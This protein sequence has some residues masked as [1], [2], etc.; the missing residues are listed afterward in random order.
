[1]AFLSRT[2]TN[3]APIP[4]DADPAKCAGLEGARAWEE[5]GRWWIGSSVC[6]SHSFYVR[7]SP[8][9]SSSLREFFGNRK[10]QL[11]PLGATKG[12]EKLIVV[13]KSYEIQNQVLTRN[14]CAPSYLVLALQLLL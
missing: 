8:T 6:L 12:N 5:V 14:S 1:M 3:T 13:G 4:S 11:P 10:V 7:Q 2:T 9:K